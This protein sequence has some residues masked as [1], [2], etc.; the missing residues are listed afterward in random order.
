MEEI[1]VKFLNIDPALMEQKL[2]GL[3]A[4]QEFKVVYQIS[5]F[6]YPDLRLNAQKSWVRL[7]SDGTN[8]TLAFKQR[9]GVKAAGENDDTMLEHEVVVSDFETTASI[10]RSIGLTEKFQEEKRRT[11][12]RLG[13]VEF[14]LD[15]MPLLKP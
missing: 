2:L 15:E 13:E 10:M 4:K 8:T 14:S 12:Y 7:R 11:L 5:T 6:D 1:E 3:G 9:Q